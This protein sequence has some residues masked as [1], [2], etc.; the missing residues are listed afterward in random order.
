[1]K[2]KFSLQSVLKNRQIQEDLA[3]KDFAEA[4]AA[5]AIEEDKLTKLQEQLH[6][7][8]LLA[9][10]C[11]QQGG[12]LGP[13]LDQITEFRKFQKILIEGQKKVIQ[14]KQNVVEAKR[15]LLRAAALEVKIMERLR[16]KKFEEY[17]F[18]RRSE[19][20]KELDELS[21]LRFEKDEH[22]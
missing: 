10:D 13:R 17:K 8:Y 3:Q 1:M 19:E 22:S 20:Q 11:T 7:S 15:D 12:A 9:G 18:K 6:K 2:F 21:I 14:E 16:E 5:L 4:Q